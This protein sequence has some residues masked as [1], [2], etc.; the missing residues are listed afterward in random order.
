MVLEP[1]RCEFLLAQG[2]VLLLG[3][4]GT[5]KTLI[6]LALGPA[7]CQRGYRV[8]FTTA[9]ALVQE[10]IEARDEKKLPRFPKLIASY[11]LLIVD[12]LGV[13]PLF[14]TAAHLLFEM[15]SQ[16]YERGS[17][18]LT[19]NLPFAD[20][21]KSLDSTASL[22]TST[23]SRWGATASAS[24]TASANETR[25]PPE[26]APQPQAPRGVVVRCPCRACR[27]SQWKL[28]AELETD[29]RRCVER[30]NSRPKIQNAPRVRISTRPR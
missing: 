5:G 17:T 10:L 22:T 26:R 15:L 12:E 28:P 14:K 11:E 23:S 25:H 6:G 7:A 2:D 18:M 1:A 21:P 27:S 16:L 30:A 13:V 9:A 3:N 19:R 29:C 20:G 4:S 24:S 8:R